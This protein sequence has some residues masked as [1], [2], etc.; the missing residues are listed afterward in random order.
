MNPKLCGQP[1]P[2]APEELSQFA[3]LIGSRRCDVRVKGPNGTFDTHQAIW[4]ARYIMVGYVVADARYAL[5]S[6][7]RYGYRPDHRGVNGGFRV[8]AET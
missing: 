3:F 7:D 5:R 2:S 1:N 6:A 4:T 8:A